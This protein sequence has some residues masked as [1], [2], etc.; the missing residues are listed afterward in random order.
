[1]LVIF[2]RLKFIEGQDSFILESCFYD[3]VFE[4][5]SLPFSKK[6]EEKVLQYIMKYCEN[7]LSKLDSISS[8]NKDNKLVDNESIEGDPEFEMAKLRLQVRFH[9]S[10]C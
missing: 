7:M 1:M 9:H 6:N 8:D 4:E 2:F 10:S 3:T 5:M